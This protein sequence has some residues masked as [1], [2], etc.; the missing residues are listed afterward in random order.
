MEGKIR[1]MW[2]YYLYH[3]GKVNFLSSLT[4]MLKVQAAECR[5][6]PKLVQVP[7]KRNTR[8]VLQRI[9]W[10]LPAPAVVSDGDVDRVCL[11]QH[12]QDDHDAAS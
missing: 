8:K 9:Y 6:I 7:E 1:I 10:Q 12:V 2:I 11:F 3:S 4:K 5:A